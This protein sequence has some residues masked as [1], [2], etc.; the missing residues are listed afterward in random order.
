MVTPVPVLIM[1]GANDPVVPSHHGSMLYEAALM[2][3]DF[4][5]TPVPGH[6]MAFA[7]EGVRMKFVLYLSEHLNMQ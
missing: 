2:P 4:W 5:E 7:D 6:I 1:H 3:K